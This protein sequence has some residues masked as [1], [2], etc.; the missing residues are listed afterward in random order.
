MRNTSGYI[1][2]ILPVL[3]GSLYYSDSPEQEIQDI[4]AKRKSGSKKQM[5]IEQGKPLITLLVRPA[6][7]PEMGF[8]QA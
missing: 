2:I 4:L 8:G 1:R 3:S 6:Y 5:K 7:T